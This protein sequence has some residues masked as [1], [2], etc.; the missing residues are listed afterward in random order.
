MVASLVQKVRQIRTWLEEAEMNIQLRKAEP[1]I[2]RLGRLAK[3]KRYPQEIVL[4]EAS[5]VVPY[6]IRRVYDAMDAMLLFIPHRKFLALRRRY[7]L[8][9]RTIACAMLSQRLVFIDQEV[10]LRDYSQPE[11]N[12]L[13][14]HEL[15]HI[16]LDSRNERLV[17]KAACLMA[18]EMG[19][20]IKEM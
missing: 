11:L 2:K 19:V 7:K 17:D 6:K 9:S 12:F 4:T 1:A 8:P 14:L 20:A 16:M 13:Y 5:S 18:K 10:S 3:A 15:A